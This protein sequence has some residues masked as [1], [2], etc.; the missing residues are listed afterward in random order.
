MKITEKYKNNN[1]RIFIQD[2]PFLYFIAL[3]IL[4]GNNY[5]RLINLL[6]LAKFINRK[7]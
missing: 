3:I 6:Q 1:K 7:L 5:D 2:N 4:K